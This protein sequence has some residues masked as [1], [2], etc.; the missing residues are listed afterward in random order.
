[1]LVTIESH[2]NPGRGAD[3]NALTSLKMSESADSSAAGRPAFGEHTTGV[4]VVGK[5]S[6]PTEAVDRPFGLLVPVPCRGDERYAMTYCQRNAVPHVAN[7][8]PVFPVPSALPKPM[9]VFAVAPTSA[10]LKVFPSATSATMTV[11]VKLPKIPR[12][13]G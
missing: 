9:N 10:T 3:E 4:S 11:Q 6:V 7:A 13:E 12:G 1:M 2:G 8:D 5:P